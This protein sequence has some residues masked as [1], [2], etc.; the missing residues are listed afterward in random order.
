MKKRYGFFGGSFNPV[1]NAHI[2]L[3]NLVAN[4]YNLDKVVLVPMGDNYNKQ[5][6]ISEKYRY[7]MLKLA[8]KNH[9]KIEVSDI[10]L[11]LPYAL[12]MLEAFQKIEKTYTEVKPY[13][14]IGA[15]NLLK[16]IRTKRF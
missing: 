13:F 16:L 12:T 5:D 10:E 3:A 15:D 2:Q 8:I 1:T 6:L 14:I 4:T 9:K 11:N 7:E